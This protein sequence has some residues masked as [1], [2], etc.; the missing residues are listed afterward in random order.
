MAQLL[1]DE[2]N[3]Y[4]SYKF[5]TKENR[6]RNLKSNENTDIEQFLSIQHLLDLNKINHKFE[7]N[8]EIQI[9]K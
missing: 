7:K 9:V 6:I 1:I 5:D 4:S 8:F 3:R 2:L